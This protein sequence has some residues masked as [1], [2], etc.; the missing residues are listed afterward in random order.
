MDALSTILKSLRVIEGNRYPCAAHWAG[1]YRPGYLLLV[2][3]A[4]PEHKKIMELIT[5]WVL[6]GTFY[7]IAGGEWLP[8]HDEVRYSVYRHTTAIEETLNHLILARPFTCF[9]L[10]DLLTEAG[11]QNKPVL[12]LDFL[13]L[14]HDA[15]IELSVRD[16]VLAQACQAIKQLSLSQPVVVLVPTLSTDAY[17]QFFPVLAAV[18]DEIL[19]TEQ[20]NETEA[21][22]DLLF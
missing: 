6:R 2:K 18:V 3:T 13:H 12:L 16:R 11:R 8:N 14:F 22:Q 1:S 17:R 21:I 5:E 15:D 19:E 9:Q 20:D 4:G 7:L 10:L